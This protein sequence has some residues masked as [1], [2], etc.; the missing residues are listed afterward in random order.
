MKIYL[1]SLEDCIRA[2]ALYNVNYQA[3]VDNGVAAEGGLC[4][5]VGVVKTGKL[6]PGPLLVDEGG[7]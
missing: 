3:N 6:G 1:P 5:A 4:R 7:E 2:C